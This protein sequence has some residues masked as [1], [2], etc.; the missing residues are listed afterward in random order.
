MVQAHRQQDLEPTYLLE[1]FCTDGPVWRVP[2]V[3]VVFSIHL[4]ANSG[5]SL[6]INDELHLTSMQ[7]VSKLP[8]STALTSLS[9]ALALKRGYRKN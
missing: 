6:R 7:D 9:V 5:H 2:S 8:E 4:P 3:L 1:I